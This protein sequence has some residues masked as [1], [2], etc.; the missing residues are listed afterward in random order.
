MNKKLKNW[1][2]PKIPWKNKR[3]VPKKPT[4][5]KNKNITFNDNNGEK[6]KKINC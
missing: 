4:N 3:K 6:S 5:E 1:V 2:D